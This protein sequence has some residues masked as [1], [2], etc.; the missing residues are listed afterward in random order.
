MARRKE[1]NELAAG[2]FIAVSVLLAVGVLLLLA[3]WRGLT[4]KRHPV[5]VVFAQ[6]SVRELA[7]GGKVLFNG[8]PVGEV[9]SVA[10][11]YADPTRIEVVM[12]VPRDL[13]L[14][15]N[16]ALYVASSPL[17]G[18]AWLVIESMGSPEGYRLLDDPPDRYRLFRPFEAS[19][20]ALPENV[21]SI[22]QVPPAG[23]DRPIYGLERPN[24]MAADMSRTMGIYDPQRTQLQE[25]IRAFRDSAVSLSEVLAQVECNLLPKV[26][27]SLANIETMTGTGKDLAQTLAGRVP[28][29]FDRIDHAVVTVDKLF[30]EQ[31]PVIADTLAKVNSL[32]GTLDGA[33]SEQLKG[34][35]EAI[36]RL[37]DTLAQA[38]ASMENIR[39]STEVARDVLVSHRDSLSDTLANFQEGSG[40]FAAALGEVRREPWRLLHRPD[41][42]ELAASN[43]LQAARDF[44]EGAADLRDAST[45]L[46]A[47]VGLRGER[48]APDDPTYHKLLADLEQSR[49]KFDKAEQA[50]YQALNVK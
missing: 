46:S 50:L 23:V 12:L 34:I 43:V 15:A 40:Q 48:L 37:N 17:G 4:E 35:S 1:R 3:D 26:D 14:Y 33:S 8:V 5:R 47:L 32:A 31:S 20:A 21:V 11:D 28:A 25:T 36:T 39:Q 7:P 9:E 18:N 22:G 42:D 41:R 2:V 49:L 45:R 29:T 19:P 24:Q 10:L 30:T 6:Q 27:A 16:A 13:K 44:A 38:R